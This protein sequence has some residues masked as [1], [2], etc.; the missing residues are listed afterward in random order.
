MVSSY[1]VNPQSSTLGYPTLKDSAATLP[2]IFITYS[3]VSSRATILWLVLIFN[4][5]GMMIC[6]KGCSPCMVLLTFV[7]LVSIASTEEV[8]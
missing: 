4:Y 1:Q 2:V 7:V 5:C 3:H 6:Y 8:T